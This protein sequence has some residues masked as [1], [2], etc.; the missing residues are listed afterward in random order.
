MLAQVHLNTATKNNGPDAA[1]L[2]AIAV[3]VAPYP[4][5]AHTFTH[6]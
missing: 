1:A 5:V 4:I 2:G 3:L 6:T